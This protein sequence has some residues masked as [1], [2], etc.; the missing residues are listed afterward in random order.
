M[1]HVLSRQSN[2][3]TDIEDNVFR[4]SVPDDA[5][6]HLMKVELKGSRIKLDPPQHLAMLEVTRLS[7]GLSLKVLHESGHESGEDEPEQLV[8]LGN[9]A[10]ELITAW[11][12]KPANSPV[13]GRAR[14]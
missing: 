12:S 5:A 1:V 8:R 2:G 11:Q 4:L 7:D 3:A 6:I 13:A 9:E 10:L 14:E